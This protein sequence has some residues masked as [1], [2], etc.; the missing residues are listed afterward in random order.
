VLDESSVLVVFWASDESMSMG[1]APSISEAGRLAGDEEREA[2]GDF[3]LG[4]FCPWA[5]RVSTPM[6]KKRSLPA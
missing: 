5:A 4:P 1:S 6:S 3:S 2:A